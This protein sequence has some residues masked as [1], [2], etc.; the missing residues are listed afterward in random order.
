MKKLKRSTNTEKPQRRPEEITVTVSKTIQHR[1]F[2]P[3]TITVS[4]RHVL[5][6]DEN[7][8]AV[9]LQVYNQ[10]A[11][12]VARYMNKELDRYSDK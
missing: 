12:S 1:Q 2:E 7:P 4:E 3:V 5:S 9:R 11:T 6:E 10:V 8:K